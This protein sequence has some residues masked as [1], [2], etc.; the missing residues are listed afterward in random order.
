MEVTIRRRLAPGIT[1][2]IGPLDTNRLQRDEAR[3]I[4]DA[5]RAA[6][7]FS[8]PPSP[9]AG[10]HLEPIL[11]RVAVRDAGREHVVT[12]SEKDEE[13]P[14]LRDLVQ[15]VVAIHERQRMRH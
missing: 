15:A 14:L 8:L 6:Q 10:E 13:N 4:E 1:E 3:A 7:F 5:V 12:V 2:V 11:D 9:V